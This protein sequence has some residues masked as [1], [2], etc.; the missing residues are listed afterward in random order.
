MGEVD[1]KEA[2]EEPNKKQPVKESFGFSTAGGGKKIKISDKQLKMAK[3]RMGEVDLKEA[4]EEP[5]KK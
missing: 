2:K 1:L 3:Q 4:K 5:N